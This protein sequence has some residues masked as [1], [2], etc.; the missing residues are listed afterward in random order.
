MITYG[1]VKRDDATGSLQSVNSSKFNKGAITAA[2]ELLA[3][4]VAGLTVNSSGE[5]GGGSVIR[6][7]GGYS[8]SASYDPLIII[9]GVP[10]ANDGVSGDRNALNIVSPNDIESTAPLKIGEVKFR[11][12]MFGLLTLATMEPI[13]HLN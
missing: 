7:R 8:L 11:A 9:D 3:G 13:F 2:P 6:I 5:P 4:K 10:V 1:T 12:M